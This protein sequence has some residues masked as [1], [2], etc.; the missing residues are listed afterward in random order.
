LA[1][2]AE[3]RLEPP[4]SEELLFGLT[5]AAAGWI[6]FE[7]GVVPGAGLSGFEAAPENAPAG[8]ARDVEGRAGFAVAEV[9]DAVE[10]R[11]GEAVALGLDPIDFSIARDWTL[12]L[13]VDRS[14]GA[15]LP[16][17]T[18]WS[19]RPDIDGF[20]T[21]TEMLGFWTLPVTLGFGTFTVM[22]GFGTLT[23]TLGFGTFTVMLG[24]G[25]LMVG[26]GMFGTTTTGFGISTALAGVEGIETKIQEKKIAQI[27]MRVRLPMATLPRPKTTK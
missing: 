2:D 25:T 4:A 19:A 27:G 9:R 15:E 13:V 22:L 3:F 11:T 16:T 18:D 26:R 6:I 17:F 5:L 14:V 1:V 24:L 23:V 7:N 21:L 8:S 10:A 12:G 20:W